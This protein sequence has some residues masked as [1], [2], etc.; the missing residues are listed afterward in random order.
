ME[1]ATPIDNDR[2]FRRERKRRAPVGNR[3]AQGRGQRPRIGDFAR[4][5]PG[6]RRRFDRD[7]GRNGNSRLADRGRKGRNA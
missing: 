7:P 5:E 2:Q 3:S 1:A 6:K 4:I